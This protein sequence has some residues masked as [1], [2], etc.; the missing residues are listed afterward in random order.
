MVV[1][2]IRDEEELLK[3][4]FGKQWEEYH[5]RTKIFLPGIM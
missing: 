3:R 1:V 5:N 2:R 4:E